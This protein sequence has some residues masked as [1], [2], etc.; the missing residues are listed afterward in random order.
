MVRWLAVFALAAALAGA[1]AWLLRGA[2][3]VSPPSAPP[4][5]VVPVTPPDPPPKAPPPQEAETLIDEWFGRYVGGQKVGWVHVEAHRGED[6]RVALREEHLT[7]TRSQIAGMTRESRLTVEGRLDDADLSVLDL[8][9]VE[10]EQGRSMVVD[11]VWGRE[12]S[13]DRT[14][15]SSCASPSRD[16]SRPAPNRSSR[17]STSPCRARSRRR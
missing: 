3:V 6:G 7:R 15:S 5:P 17:S 1:A 13:A 16:D 10:E 8:H 9:V 14:T 2:P 12:G 4:P 11:V